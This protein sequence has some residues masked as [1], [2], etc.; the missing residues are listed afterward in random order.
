MLINLCTGTLPVSGRTV[1]WTQVVWHQHLFATSLPTWYTSGIQQCMFIEQLLYWARLMGSS[2]LQD[3]HDICMEYYI[4]LYVSHTV[5]LYFSPFFLKRI[6]TPPWWCGFLGCLKAQSFPPS[7]L[8]GSNILMCKT[9]WL[10]LRAESV[11]IQ[12]IKKKLLRINQEKGRR[13]N[14]KMSKIFI[15]TLHQRGHPNGQ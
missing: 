3:I 1:I 15:E 9:N 6:I 14:R 7:C 11:H 4:W 5:F 12:N 13:P 8:W 2:Q 10:K